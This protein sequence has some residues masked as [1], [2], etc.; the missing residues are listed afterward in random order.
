MLSCKSLKLKI[1]ISVFIPFIILLITIC[2]YLTV[3]DRESNNQ[4]FANGAAMFSSLVN[5]SI[6]I[7]DSWLFDRMKVV[8]TLFNQENSRAVSRLQL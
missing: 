7:I 6:N 2:C 4:N 8:D 1:F 3:R 5:D